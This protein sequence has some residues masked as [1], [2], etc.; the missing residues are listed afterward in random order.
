MPTVCM[1]LPANPFGRFQRHPFL[2][3]EMEHMVVQRYLSDSRGLHYWQTQRKPLSVFP[4]DSGNE[5]ASYVDHAGILIAVSVDPRCWLTRIMLHGSP[6]LNSEACYL[7]PGM[8]QHA[9]LDSSVVLCVGG[10]LSTSYQG[11]QLPP[12]YIYTIWCPA[13]DSCLRLE[14]LRPQQLLSEVFQHV[15]A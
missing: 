10:H 4:F 6:L 7:I 9:V 1:L 15:S 11:L 13:E 8:Q 14:L 12:P 2:R 5:S 3:A